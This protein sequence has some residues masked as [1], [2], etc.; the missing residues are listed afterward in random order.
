[1]FKDARSLSRSLWLASDTLIL[2]VG[3]GEKET[4]LQRNCFP[5]GDHYEELEV[6]I[7]LRAEGL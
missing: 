7:N 6:R 2:P 5:E 1:M 4:R 3:G